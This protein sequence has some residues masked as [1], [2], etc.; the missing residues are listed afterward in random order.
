MRDDQRGRAA[1]LLTLACGLRAAYDEMMG[2]ST[3]TRLQSMS[4]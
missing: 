2:S 3:I 4:R 1:R